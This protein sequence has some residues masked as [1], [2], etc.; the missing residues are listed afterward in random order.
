M[1]KIVRPLDLGADID[2]AERVRHAHVSHFTIPKCY[3]FHILLVYI[4]NCV[5]NVLCLELLMQDGWTPLMMASHWGNVECVK[6]LLDRGAH[7]NLQNNVS[8]V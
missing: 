2:S 1:E 8:Q 3:H 7:A 5:Y 4:S 6:V